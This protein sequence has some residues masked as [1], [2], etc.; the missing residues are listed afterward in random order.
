MN[1]K[2]KLGNIV[3]FNESCNNIE[4][5]NEYAA[6]EMQEYKSDHKYKIVDIEQGYEEI[7]YILQDVDTKSVIYN[8]V[9]E[10]ELELAS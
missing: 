5:Y 9:A 1:N 2:F 8:T 6:V 10:W 4:E 7:L 3:K